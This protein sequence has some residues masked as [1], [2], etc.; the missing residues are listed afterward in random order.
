[1][2]PKCWQF[3]DITICLVGVGSHHSSFVEIEDAPRGVRLCR[4]F[5]NKLVVLFKAKF[6][7]GHE[8][9]V[10]VVVLNT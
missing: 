4:Q 2:R 10:E 9:L 5:I 3:H 6:G 8:I 1:M 7:T